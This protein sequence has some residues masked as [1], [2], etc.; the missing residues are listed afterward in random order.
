MCGWVTTKMALI[1]RFRHV[2]GEVL[3]SKR[4]RLQVR[5]WPR[6]R[7]VWRLLEHWERIGKQVMFQAGMRMMAVV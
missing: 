2:I 1:S 7:V 4:V 6:L 3:I 5:L